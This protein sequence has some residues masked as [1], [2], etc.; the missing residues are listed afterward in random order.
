MPTA[1]ANLF[2]EGNFAPLRH[3]FNLA[4]TRQFEIRG[5][6]PR[7][8]NGS[9]YRNGP[10][11]QFEPGPFYHWFLGDGMLHA[12][13]LQRGEV[14]YLN[15]YVATPTLELERRAGRNLFLGQRTNM[16]ANLQ[17]VGGNLISL[18]SGLIRDKNADAY[19]RLI[20]K[21][22]TSVLAFREELFALVESSPPIRLQPT[23]LASEGFEKFD[24]GF[25]APFTAHPKTDPQ[26]GYLYA[27]GYR[28][29]GG[30]RLEYYV[31][32]PHG[33]LVSRTAVETDYAAM[34]HDFAITRNY[35]VV[36]VF[37]AV[38]S[39]ASIRRGRIA[40][41]QP[42]KGA[43][44]IVMNKDGDTASLRRFEL[45]VGY[46]YHYANAY[47]D[48]KAIVVDAIRY[49][50]VPLMG[51]DTE[52]RAELFEQAN[53]GYLTRFR[54]DLASGKTETQV[55]H[56]EHYAEF[57]VIDPRLVGEKYEHSFAASASGNNSSAAG[58][59]DG[60]VSYEL[61]RGKVKADIH[62]FPRGHF[63]GE[64]IFVPT[65]KPGE[66]KGYLLNLIYS[67]E[68][69]RSYLAVFDVAKPDKKPLCEIWLPHR[70]PYGFHGTWRQHRN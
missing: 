6:V 45:P 8:L 53:N 34:I 10:N 31:I 63:G 23:T 39:L 69:N 24:A 46:V 42:E 70:V 56:S 50:R 3:E 33:K 16:L 41:W 59:F 20:A 14:S 1:P 18:I 51:S 66:R 9:F 12:F 49:E 48:G 27:F 36:P 68:D 61:S 15:R 17:L 30:P 37:P 65:G 44:V 19:T 54:I 7:D 40:E 28:V 2:L 13:H 29:A 57:P 62:D 55:L 64:P 58:I 35:A 5:K 22:N 4:K 32:N 43:S 11:P 60:Q 26:T 52:I 21:A 38:T 47:E 67:T 25:M